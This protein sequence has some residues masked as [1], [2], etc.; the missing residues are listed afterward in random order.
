MGND[1]LAQLQAAGR[2]GWRARLSTLKV[3]HL[4][5]LAVR[6]A[7]EGKFEGK[8]EA[9]QALLMPAVDLVAPLVL[10]GHQR[11]IS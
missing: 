1:A 2:G 5:G 9:K 11:F 10:G 6:L 3:V 4:D 7:V 8:K